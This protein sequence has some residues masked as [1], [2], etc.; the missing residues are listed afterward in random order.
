MTGISTNGGSPLARWA[1]WSGTHPGRFLLIAL[2][3]TII[4]TVGASMLTIE[5]TFFSIMPEDSPQ[6]RDM[7]R[8]A[9]EYPFVSALVAVVDGRSLPRGESKDAA[10]TVIDELSRTFSAPDYADAVSTTIPIWF[11]FSRR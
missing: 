2:A 7:E 11:R 9:E 1:V 6:V 4:L 8:I 3:V 5:M 10:I